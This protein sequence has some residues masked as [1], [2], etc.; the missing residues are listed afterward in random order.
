MNLAICDKA[1]SLE[2]ISNLTINLKSN[3]Q[4]LFPKNHQPEEFYNDPYEYEIVGTH[5]LKVIE[6]ELYMYGNEVKNEFI[7]QSIKECDNYEIV[8][9]IEIYK[10][11]IV[12]GTLK[13]VGYFHNT[14]YECD[15]CHHT[16]IY[17]EELRVWVLDQQEK[18]G[19]V[20][21]SNGIVTILVIP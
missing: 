10:V 9:T 11:E 19:R 13:I 12:D 6:I 18:D 15:V 5:E 14:E 16:F 20:H 4:V 17:N 7:L 1:Q 8:E 2:K 21:D 3:Q